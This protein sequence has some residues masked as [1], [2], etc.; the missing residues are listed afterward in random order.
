MKVQIVCFSFSLF[1]PVSFLLGGWIAQR[2]RS[3]LVAKSTD[4]VSYVLNQES[5]TEI[6][7]SAHF[8]VTW[9]PDFVITRGLRMGNLFTPLLPPFA[10]QLLA[11]D[12]ENLLFSWVYLLPN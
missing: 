12:L 10:I 8:I 7:T 4:I 3:L 11:S 6:A 9:Y 1:A 2:T 5:L